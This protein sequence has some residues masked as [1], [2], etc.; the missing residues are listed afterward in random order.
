MPFIK[1]WSTE[2]ERI[3]RQLS[4]TGRAYTREIKLSRE[5][6]MKCREIIENDYLDIARVRTSKKTGKTIFVTP[7]EV[8]VIPKPGE[9]G[10]NFHFK[11]IKIF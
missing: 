10:I 9:H 3:F 6:G 7:P 5:V 4:L 1:P 8:V 2:S 11:H